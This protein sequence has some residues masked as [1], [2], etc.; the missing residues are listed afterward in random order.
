[1]N[2]QKFLRL[3]TETVPDLKFIRTL[4]EPFKYLH[5]N[6]YLKIQKLKDFQVK[7]KVFLLDR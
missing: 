2:F 4:L 7:P 3:N 6:V 1:M 5:N